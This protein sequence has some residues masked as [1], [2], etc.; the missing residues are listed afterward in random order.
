M[1]SELV[2]SSVW[3]FPLMRFS[4][5]KDDTSWLKQNGV[6]SGLSITE[7]DEFVYVDAAM[8][9]I[10]VEDIEISYHQGVLRIN[11]EMKDEEKKDRKS[12]TRM[13]SS[14]SY[15]VAVPGEVDLNADPEATCADGIVTV[16]FPKMRAA[17]LKKISVKNK[18][19]GGRSKKAA[20]EKVETK[21]EEKEELKAEEKDSKPTKL[22][23]KSE[24]DIVPDD[25]S[26][27]TDESGNVDSVVA[28][29]D[30]SEVEDTGNQASGL[31]ERATP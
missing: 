29:V 15:Q 1:S 25:G 24:P 17:T 18:A 11:G 2:P 23:G 26:S 10:K 21:T 8:P 13:T 19:S 3:S 7:D 31:E 22:A 30:E 27:M 28:D 14:Y 5:L 16:A 9:G 4:S 20:E 6:P 12:Y